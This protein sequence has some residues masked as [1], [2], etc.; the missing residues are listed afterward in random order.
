[1]R[2]YRA[3]TLVELLIALIITGLVMAALITLFFSVFKSYEFHQDITEAKQRGHIALAAIQPFVL[4]AGL[5]LPNTETDF[6]NAFSGLTKLLPADNTKK[7][8]GYV[9]L[10]SDDTYKLT[11]THEAPALWL[12][13]SVPGGA[14]VNY[15]YQLPANTDV[16]VPLEGFDNLSAT[17]NLSTNAQLIESWVSFPSTTA[18]FRNVATPL[19]PNL[20]LRFSSPTSSAVQTV[21]A[22]DEVHFVRAAK[23]F[24]RNNT[25]MIDRLL[26]GSNPQPAVDGIAGLWCTFDPDENRVLT[27]R[28]LARASTSRTPGI[29]SGIEGWPT[30]A[31]AH[32]P[33]DSK[34]R[35]VVVSRSWRIRN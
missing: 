12:V 7:F 27:V 31:D 17:T 35:Y 14:G 13:Y 25:L 19:S 8:S 5:G 4:N 26:Q 16:V 3:F 30:A 32:W 34:Y 18:P 28:V 23:I 10:A 24:V 20:T 29:Q 1:M 9:Q 15:E 11:A 2:R 33:R 6:Q 21:A 22:F